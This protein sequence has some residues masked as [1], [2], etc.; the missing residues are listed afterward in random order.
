MYNKNLKNE[1][2]PNFTLKPRYKSEKSPEFLKNSRTLSRWGEDG[3]RIRVRSGGKSNACLA[4]WYAVQSVRTWRIVKSSPHEHRGGG[5]LRSRWQWVIRV[6]P[7]LR[8]VIATWSFLDKSNSLDQGRTER[9]IRPSLERVTLHWSCQRSH[10]SFLIWHFRSSILTGKRS[11]DS[12]AI[13]AS[14]AAASA[15]SFPSI[16]ICPGIHIKTT[17]QPSW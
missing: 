5:R 9:L 16:S 3:A 6:W 11:V 4:G 2:T 17:L 13:E 12:G 10:V 15:F 14:L 1:P 8:R 7:S